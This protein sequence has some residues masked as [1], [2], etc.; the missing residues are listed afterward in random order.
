MTGRINQFRNAVAAEI[1]KAIPALREC[2]S[3]FG[4]FNFEELE[5]NMPCAPAVLVSILR[6]QLNYTANAQNEALLDCTAFII[7]EGE[8]RDEQAWDIAEVISILASP[9]QQWTLKNI[10]F[11]ENV[12]IEQVIFERLRQS[13]VAVIS[14]QWKQRL[15]CL[16]DG[17]FENEQKTVSNLQLEIDGGI[18]DVG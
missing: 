12:V 1:K 4:Q 16:G 6:A 7:T 3:Y 10:G 13:G 11:P 9:H 17:L 14:V 8:K 2:R 5:E 18:V 15:I